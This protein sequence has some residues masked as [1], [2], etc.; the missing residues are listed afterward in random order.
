MQWPNEAVAFYASHVTT[1]WPP[2][3]CSY[4]LTACVTIIFVYPA[5][6]LCQQPQDLQHVLLQGGREELGACIHNICWWVK[7]LTLF[8]T[9]D[10][11]SRCI[12]YFHPFEIWWFQPIQMGFTVTLYGAAYNVHVVSRCYAMSAATQY[13]WKHNP[14][15]TDAIHTL[16]QSREAN[17]IPGCEEKRNFQLEN[18]AA[19]Y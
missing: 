17:S 3:S 19:T 1:Y 13:W 5:F 2:P 12:P 11:L 8:Q 7:T 15:Q 6:G 4:L 16:F 14:D 10:K 9:K 18:K